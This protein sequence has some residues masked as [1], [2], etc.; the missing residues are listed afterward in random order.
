MSIMLVVSNLG[1]DVNNLRIE[2]LF[3]AH[4]RV[5]SAQIVMEQIDGQSLRQGYVQMSC[6]EEAKRAV[7]ALHGHVV[8]GCALG[9]DATTMEI[10]PLITRRPRYGNGRSGGG[11][12]RSG[13]RV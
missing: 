11:G 10:E 6:D 13:R 3:A 5:L 9:V 7:A 1:H 2:K 4:G 12:V 8:D